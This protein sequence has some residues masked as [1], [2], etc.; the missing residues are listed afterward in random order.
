MKILMVYPEYPVTFWSF[1]YALKFVS[2]K[3]AFP[4]LGLVTVAAMLPM[5]WDIRLV[6]MN[7]DKLSDREILWADFVMVSAMLIQQQS[8]HDLLAR[9]DGLH[10]PVIAGG[11]LFN[12]LPGEY[13]GR[14]A[15]LVLNEAELTLPRFLEDLAAGTPRPIYQ[16]DG[17]ADLAQTPVPR[18]DLIRVEN[19]ATLMIQASRGCPFD[20]E[21][22]DITQLYGRIPRVKSADRLLA[23]LEAIHGLGWR[24]NLFIVDDNFIGN[25]PKIKQVLVRV[26]EWMRQRRYPFALF[27]EASI[28][29]ADDDELIELMGEAGFDTVFIGLETPNE[30]SL[31]ECSKNQNCRRDLVASVQKLQRAGFHVL[32]G[33]IVGFD[34]DDENI[35]CRQIR[36]IQE[37]GVVTAMVGLLNA[38][39]R[40]RLWKRLKREQ[41]IRTATSGDNTDG[42]INFI[43][44]MDPDVLIGGYRHVVRTIYSPKHFYRRV[45]RFMEKYRP[46][47]KRPLRWRDLKAFLKTVFYLGILGNGWSQW[48]YWKMLIKSLVHYRNAI[49]D[50]VTL[51][52]YG[53]HFRKVAKRL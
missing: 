1:D 39:P 9:C 23:E 48:Y 8:V 37:S 5:Q 31:K 3:A 38:L 52:A 35:F 49:P 50:A 16:S 28:N 2:K 46:R 43:P 36:F 51:M 33:Y 24:G 26:I 45:S 13:A 29:L 15:H 53:H 42:T 19:Y 41:R 40:T 17:F 20:C 32:G 10:K 34:H 11:P 30:E 7:I 6:D 22:C 18:W 14:V 21:F 44:A 12:S 47:R 25:K 4:P 27:T